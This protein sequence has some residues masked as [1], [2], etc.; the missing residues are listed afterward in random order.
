MTMVV[1]V[2]LVRLSG[3]PAV[4]WRNRAL[5]WRSV[6]GT[7]SLL[8]TFYSLAHLPVTDAVTI[9]SMGPVWIA[10]ILAV[11]FGRPAPASTWLLAGLALTGVYAMEQ[12]RFHADWLALSVAVFGSVTAA[13]A[14][15]S[16]SF[17]GQL[18]ALTVV[19][20]YS[21][22][23]T[24]TTLLLCLAMPGPVVYDPAMSVGKWSWLIPL[25]ITGTI[26]QL[27][28][29]SAY[30]HGVPT[31]VALVGISQMVFA[32]I[33][34]MMF[35]QESFSGI[36]FVGMA[37]IAFAIGW[38]ILLNARSAPVVREGAGE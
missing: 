15:V 8:C 27:F 29:T 13:G 1:A 7:I 28:L 26:G 6:M 30:G 5:W 24:L 16:L 33:L 31:L 10:I 37:A 14:M 25:G 19:A 22:F 23:A 9:F 38:S 4:L 3:R 2:G 20:Q 12:P 36:K 32:A 11:G 35:W 21:S 34:D 17:C 18:N